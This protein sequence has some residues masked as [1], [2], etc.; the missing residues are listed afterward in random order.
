MFAVAAFHLVGLFSLRALHANAFSALTLPCPTPAAVK[1]ALLAKLLERDGPERAQETL[2]WLAPLAVWWRPPATIATTTCTVRIWTYKGDR[3]GDP[4]DPSRG[5]REY[6][7]MADP[8][9]L[10]LGRVPE[11]HWE[12]L[13]FALGHLRALGIAESLVQPLAP[14]TWE[15]APPPG[16]VD[17]TAE[18][19][20]DATGLAV[21]LDD[22]GPAPAWERLNVYRVH[23]R[24]AVPRIGMERVRR[25]VT[26]PYEVRRWSEAGYVLAR[27]GG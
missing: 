8:F 2:D 20:D 26:L 13:A 18:A 14:A 1:L 3:P 4:L 9:G 21:V 16:Y 12:D 19:G 24:S 6:A 25:I 17:L 10:A 22:L 5:M 11:P 27:I 15:E 23:E 7:H